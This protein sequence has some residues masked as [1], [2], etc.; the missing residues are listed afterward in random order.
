MVDKD[1]HDEKWDVA[2]R[3]RHEAKE[4]RPAFSESLHVRICRAVE[5]SEMAEPPRTAA[6][7]RLG[8]AGIVGA[9]A[10]TLAVAVLYLVW[11]GNPTS[12]PVP[13]PSDMAGSGGQEDVMVELERG[14]D[15]KLQ[16]PTDVPGNLAVEIGLL[17]DSTLTNQRWAYLDHDAQLATRMLLDQL[18]GSI[19][20]PEEDL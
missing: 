19:A 15:G 1:A 2:D 5:Q 17:V 7:P 18:P 20:W 14:P 6:A 9:V 11:Q 13:K 3:L 16:S 4:T 12:G 8:R 10:A